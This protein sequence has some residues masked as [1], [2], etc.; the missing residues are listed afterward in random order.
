MTDKHLER[1]IELLES[2]DAKL[3]SLPEIKIQLSAL[4]ERVASIEASAE[5]SQQGLADLC[6]DACGASHEG[7]HLPG[8]LGRIAVAVERLAGE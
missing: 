6:A 1:M 2:I 3:H 4:T 7:R 8:T 5:Y